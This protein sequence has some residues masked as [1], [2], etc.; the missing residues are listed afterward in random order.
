MKVV[1]HDRRNTVAL[2]WSA[3]G[4]AILWPA[5]ASRPSQS[6]THQRSRRSNRTI[7]R[8]LHGADDAQKPMA[9]V[10]VVGATLQ[11]P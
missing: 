9:A 8:Q 11:S 6:L 10:A 1:A 4:S 7:C 3:T 2:R 5:I